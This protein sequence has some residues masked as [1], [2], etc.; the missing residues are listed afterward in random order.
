[1]MLTLRSQ[2]N[3]EKTYK[4]GGGRVNEKKLGST[5]P[6]ESYFTW[7]G[8]SR[9]LVPIKWPRNLSP[10]IVSSVKARRL[11]SLSLCSLPTSSASHAMRASKTPFSPLSSL[12]DWEKGPGRLL[13]SHFSQKQNS[14]P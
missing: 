6:E 9:V 10:R 12:E 3:R 4:G 7:Q 13:E 5:A 1:M 2:S 8:T 11:L 14:N